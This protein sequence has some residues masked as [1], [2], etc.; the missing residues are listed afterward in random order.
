MTFKHTPIK[1]VEHTYT[2]ND[3]EAFIIDENYTPPPNGVVVTKCRYIDRFHVYQNDNIIG[4]A[5]R[6][7]GEYTQ[8]ELD[9][10]DHF[11]NEN[12]VVYDI[13]GN[14]G[15]HALGFSQ[16]AKHVHTFEPNIKN[17][18][19]LYLNVGTKSNVTIH[20]VACS[21][22]AGTSY[23]SDYDIN[24]LGN[25]GECMLSDSGQPCKLVKIDDLG[26]PTPQVVKI[27][28][29]GHEL[30]VFNGMRNTIT[31]SKPVILY[32]AMHGTGFDLIYDF[33]HDEL[34]Y[35]IYW[36]PATNFNPNNFNK[37]TMNVFGHGGVIN[38][39]A[40]PN[41][42]NVTINGLELMT[43]RNDTH[44]KFIQRMIDKRGNNV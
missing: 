12:T 10:L 24:G 8:I 20:E 30:S 41:T 4:A 43:D 32:E 37:Q 38:C 14:I 29:E 17:L 34:G 42:I 7:Y 6:L 28:V 18:Q 36:F 2:H 1:I 39:L 21:D 26:L 9:A 13:G 27:D 15:Y 33:L 23:I 31:N 5:L 11:I 35:T 44:Q 19:L 25:F 22:H 3:S 16:K 40:I